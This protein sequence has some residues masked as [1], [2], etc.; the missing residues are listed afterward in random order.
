MVNND[1]TKLP[2]PNE[3]NAASQNVQKL[4]QDIEKLNTTMQDSMGSAFITKTDESIDMIQN[5]STTNRKV[6][7]TIKVKDIK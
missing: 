1:E 7:K 5:E 4:T 6:I 2:N 3:L